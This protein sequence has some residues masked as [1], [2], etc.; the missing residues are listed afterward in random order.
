MSVKTLRNELRRLAVGLGMTRCSCGVLLPRGLSQPR[1]VA[2]LEA[3]QLPAELEALEERATPDEARELK[4]ILNRYLKLHPVTSSAGMM[5]GA[6]CW[7]CST[8]VSKACRLARWR[9]GRS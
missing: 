9:S 1:P 5:R 8:G 3:I 7:P 6:G 2:I 4:M